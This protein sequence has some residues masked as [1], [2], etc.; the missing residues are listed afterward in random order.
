M[1]DNQREYWN[2]IAGEKEFTT[3]LDVNL[4]TEFADKND[5]ILDFGCGYGRTLNQIYN[6]DYRNLIGYDFAS[7]M[8]KRGKISYPHLDLRVSTNNKTDLPSNSVDVVLLFAVLTCIID[9]DK[10]RAIIDEIKRVLKP[11]GYIYINDFLINS[12]KRNIQR[13]E[14]FKDKYGN[15]GVFELPEGAVLRHYDERYIQILMKDFR[16]HNYKKI[17]F[18]TMNG[19]I[20]NGFVFVGQK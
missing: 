6:L 18:K 9:N 1:K 19:N 4:F 13:Y 3:F 7:E 14:R 10:Q 12:D 11:D 17:T 5:R 8:I 2:R 16:Q 20:S 15:Y